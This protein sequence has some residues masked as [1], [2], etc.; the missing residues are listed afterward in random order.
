MH[1][2]RTQSDR[3][4]A[5][6]YAGT[7]FQNIMGIRLRDRQTVE[8]LIS[9]L[10][11]KR[12]PK[13]LARQM[14]KGEPIAPDVE[15]ALATYAQLT[16][17]SDTV[18]GWER[19]FSRLRE[20][21]H[22]AIQ[23]SLPGRLREVTE[24]LQETTDPARRVKLLYCRAI[25]EFRLS[26]EAPGDP[27]AGLSDLHKAIKTT[28]ALKQATIEARNT[29]SPLFSLIADVNAAAFDW[30]LMAL[31]GE[32]DQD[33]LINVYRAGQ[34]ACLKG[35]EQHP[36][37]IGAYRDAAEYT[38]MLIAAG[39]DEK[40]VLD[41]I[42]LGLAKIFISQPANYVVCLLQDRMEPEAMEQIELSP[43][44]Q[45]LKALSANDSNGRIARL[46]RSFLQQ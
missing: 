40:T 28:K 7:N 27:R 6:V 18:F 46:D 16:L 29:V 10:C 45:R 20:L 42:V 32:V 23:P 2:V 5:K 9:I 21:I 4:P 26:K 24:E 34:K 15:R 36:I 1:T 25:G 8:N 14:K 11:P 38:A 19:E 31:T 41:S 12:D 13:S 3:K 37:W 33:K 44:F 35:I 22:S 30:H 39:F 17:F 43:T